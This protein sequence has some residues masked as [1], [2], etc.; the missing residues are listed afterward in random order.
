MNRNFFILNRFRKGVKITKIK[1]TK[2][3]I[4]KRGYRDILF[5]KSLISKTFYSLIFIKIIYGIYKINYYFI[6][7]M[8]R[9][10]YNRVV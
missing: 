1:P 7:S 10:Y 5:Q 2:L 8:V 3:L 4:K 9:L 6:Q